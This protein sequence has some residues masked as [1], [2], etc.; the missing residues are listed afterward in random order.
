MLV[1][2]TSTIFNLALAAVP[3]VDV[4]LPVVVHPGDAEHDGPL[5]LDEPL[6]DGVLLDLGAGLDDGLQGDEDLHDGLEE[7][8]LLRVA[9]LQVAVDALKVLVAQFV[10]D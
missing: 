9:L 6:D 2:I 8:F 10:F 5:G 3:A 7:L 4:G 1:A